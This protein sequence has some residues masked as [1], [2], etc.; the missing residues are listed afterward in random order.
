MEQRNLIIAIA[1]SVVILIGSSVITQVFFPPKPAATVTQTASTGAPAAPSN[2]TAPSAPATATEQPLAD[3]SQVLA[4]TTRIAIHSPRLSG[5]IDLKGG[6]L[7]DLILNDYRETVDP[8]SPNI[9]LLSPVGAA[10]AYYAD[11]GWVAQEEGVALP[12]ANTVWQAE[13]DQL[14]PG[15]PVTLIWDNGQGLKFERRFELDENFMF[16]VTQ[17]VENSS[18]QAVTLFPY[19]L[20]ARYGTP[21]LLNYYIL[22]EG[23]LGVLDGKLDEV[24]YKDLR[25]KQKVDYSS[26]GGWLGITDK[27]WLV[28]LIPDQGTKLSA[29][30]SHALQGTTDLYQADYRG[31]AMPLAAGQSV[32]TATQLFAGAKEVRLLDRYDEQNGVPLFDR[33]V[34]F[35]W[36]YFLTKPIFKVLDFLYHQIGN[37]GISILLL[38]VFIRLLLFPLANKSYKAMSKMKALGPEMTKLKERFKDDKARM[39]QEIMALYKK[40]KVNPAAGCLPIVVQIPIFFSL[41]KVLFVTIEMRH[42]PFFG[43]IRDLSAPDPTT[44]L[45]LFGLL[46]YTVPNLGP[47]HILS[48]GVW[49]IIMGFTMWL[50]QRLNPAPPDPVQARIMSLLPIIFTFMLGSFPAGLVIYWAWNNTLSVAQQRFIM[51]RMGVK[52]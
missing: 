8:T 43:W 2:G 37:F 21:H 26:T 23:L 28:A 20:V 15:H 9:V 4:T 33:A 51:W 17:R 27:Y 19:G 30:F 39:Q 24:K 22:H 18:G 1:V 12:N 16:K 35:G 40:E 3:R 50:Q 7:D 5:S 47:L 41:Y 46:P 49:P 48:I 10:N 38:T 25:E 34:D 6:R 44:I 52:V 14:A 42:A 45:N 32:E 36:F 13:G 29:R 31:D 11:F